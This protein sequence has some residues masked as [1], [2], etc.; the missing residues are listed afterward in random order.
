M[1]TRLKAT[2]VVGFNGNAHEVWRDGEVV[3]SGQTIEFVGRG[4][5]GHVDHTVDY[6]QA[7]IGPGLIDLDA[8][9]DLDSGVL[10]LDN[11]DKREMGRLWS[12]D[13]LREGSRE[14]YTAEEEAFKYRYAFAQ[15]IRNGIT[16]VLPITSMYYRRWAENYDE[17][18]Q[19]AAIAGELGIRTYIGPCYMSGMTYV[20]A[21]RTLAP[22][23]DEARGLAGLAQAIRF[24]RDFDGSHEGR[25]RGMLAPDRIET[26]TPA[27]LER[28]A[29]ASAE[30]NAPVRLHCC[31]S[32]YE[33]EQVQQLRG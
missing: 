15:L 25:V 32:A 2:F 11:G 20:R 9:G 13:Y 24:F 26:C 8:L 12:E 16:T 19:V 17:F 33:F 31:Q 18:A 5:A 21:D 28:T 10:G 4:F 7:L 6:G 14:S 30:L 23:W 1:R 29:A 3:F 22:F 27:L